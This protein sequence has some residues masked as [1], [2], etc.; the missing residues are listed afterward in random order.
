M[1]GKGITVFLV[2]FVDDL[3]PVTPRS[4]SAQPTVGKL[5]KPRSGNRTYPVRVDN[6][7]DH[8][9]RCH[10]QGAQ[11]DGRIVFGVKANKWQRH[12]EGRRRRG[13]WLLIACPANIYI[14]PI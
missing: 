7:R 14:Y 13:T 11:K 2:E 10:E 4:N 1:V 9:N 12:G 3:R 6:V 8:M 5:G